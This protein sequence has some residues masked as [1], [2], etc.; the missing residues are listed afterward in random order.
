MQ[1]SGPLSQHRRSLLLAAVL[2]PGFAEAQAPAPEP[3][4]QMDPMV[5]T[6]LA[7][8]IVKQTE[9]PVLE[10]RFGAAVVAE[11][12]FLYV[13]GGS[14]SEG[15]RLDSIERIDLRTGKAEHWANLRIARRHHRAVLRDGRIYVLG[16]TS[17]PATPNNQPQGNEPAANNPLTEE[18]VEFYG[19]DPPTGELFPTPPIQLPGY[20]HEQSMEIVDL[21]TG[22][23]T[24]GPEM[25]FRKAL[26][27]CVVVNGCILVIGGQKEKGRYLV[28]TNTTEVFDLRTQRWSVGVNM[29]TPRRC[30]AA[31]VDGYVMVV[32]GFRGFKT[33]TTVE[34]FNPRDG[35][36]RRL[37]DIAEPVNPASA[38]WE[39]NHLLLF[40]GQEVRRRQLAY[41]LLTKQLAAY[42]LP[43][44]DSDFAAAIKHGGKIYIVGGASLRLHQTGPGLQVFTPAPTAEPTTPDTAR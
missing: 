26:F 21:A 39:G 14:N 5:V 18:L 8:P 42:P 44:P 15:T 35:G 19:E 20:R 17:G 3:P 27:G 13:I 31:V 9:H 43:L 1:S 4:Y 40:G 38:V 41:N 32:G 6:A 30:T 7:P 16:G 2:L 33:L 28:S 25:P 24:L 22:R 34:V 11:G 23:V 36:W 29:P 37:P 10:P 12:D